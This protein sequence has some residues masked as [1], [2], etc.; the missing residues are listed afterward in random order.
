MFVVVLGWVAADAFGTGAGYL[1]AFQSAAALTATLFLSHRTDGLNPLGVMA[2]TLFVRAAALAV[3]AGAWLAVGSPPA[4]A[5]A[6]CLAVLAAGVSVFRP[7]MQASLPALSPSVALLPAVNALLDTTDRIARLLGP[8]LVSLAST[9]VALVHFVTLDTLCF[10]AAGFALL[11][12]R[13]IRPIPVTP[14]P[15]RRPLEA[16]VRGA[17]VVLAHAELGFL[18]RWW[19]IV[20]GAWYAAFFVGLPLMIQ[21]V[22]PG[23]AGIADFGLVLSCY[24]GAN[25]LATLVIG[26]R[27]LPRRPGVLIFSGNLCLGAGIF[28]LGLA[29]LAA[30]PSWQVAGFCAAAGVAAIGGPMQDITMATMR[31]TDLPR[32]DLP[33]AVRAFMATNALGTLITLLAAP[34]LFDRLGVPQSILLGGLLYGAVGVAGVWRFRRAVRA[35]G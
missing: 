15:A 6:L 2:A 30:P 12:V 18:L 23:P 31:Q 10:L 34:T 9:W 27:K 32:A 17:R 19:G 20:N 5:L 14:A 35:D 3:V 13:R 11:T 33:G 25:L 28:G 4:W 22:H 24:G 1:S 16:L 29:G 8:G 7:A 21:A 26:N